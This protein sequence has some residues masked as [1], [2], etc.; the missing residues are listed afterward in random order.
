MMII[1]YILDNIFIY[2]YIL[3][4]YLLIDHHPKLKLLIDGYDSAQIIRN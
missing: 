4:R 3:I 1:Q 2:L